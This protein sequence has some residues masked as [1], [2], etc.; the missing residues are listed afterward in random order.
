MA[1][2]PPQEDDLE[3]KMMYVVDF[4][5]FRDKFDLRHQIIEMFAKPGPR[6]YLFQSS[7][8]SYVLVSLLVAKKPV[9]LLLTIIKKP[10]MILPIEMMTS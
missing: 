10:K 4:R 9:I 2:A 8:F 1:L 7:V 5:S 6:K 3:K